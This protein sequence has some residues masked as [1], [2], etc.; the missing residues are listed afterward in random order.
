ELHR[1]PALE[2]ARRAVILDPGNADA[3]MVLGYIHSYE[4]DLSRADVEFGEA[5][6]LNPS[7]ADALALLSD[8]RVFQGRASQGIES[9]ATAF[10][11]NPYPQGSTI[12][13]WDPPTMPR[14]CTKKR[15]R[16]SNIHIE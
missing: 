6:R 2:T 3:Q 12:G 13:C 10:R 15:S 11:L 14:I 8:L 5:L 7:H 1:V 9:V 16:P 4:A